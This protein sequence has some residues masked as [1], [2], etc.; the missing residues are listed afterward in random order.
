VID[1]LG[2]DKRRR[3]RRRC[4]CARLS[5]GLRPRATSTRWSPAFEP[6]SGRLRVGDLPG[7]LRPGSAQG[8]GGARRRR[9]AVVSD[10]RRAAR[11]RAHGCGW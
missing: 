2:L 5:W 8:D 4:Q 9:N 1:E 11:R 7:L 10:E 6:P 3:G